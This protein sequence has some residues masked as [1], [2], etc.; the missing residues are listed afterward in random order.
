MFHCPQDGSFALH[1]AVEGGALDKVRV[2][3]ENANVNDICKVCTRRGMKGG[4]GGGGGREG[5]GRGR[6]KEEKGGGG[7]M[8]GGREGRGGGGR[9]ER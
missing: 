7:G 3:L 5:G 2:L 8:G 9:R 4:G 6:G 1:H